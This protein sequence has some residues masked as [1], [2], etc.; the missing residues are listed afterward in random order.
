VF[1]ALLR[2]LT[3]GRFRCGG[4]YNGG[5]SGGGGR[6]LSV[7]VLLTDRAQLGDEIKSID[8]LRMD[9]LLQSCQSTATQVPQRFLVLL[10]PCCPVAPV[11]LVFL[12]HVFCSSRW[13]AKKKRA[14]GLL[15]K[16]RIFSLDVQ[17]AQ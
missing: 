1:L 11:G 4:G 13:R 9:L 17:A 15:L 2:P 7:D 14:I 5:G 16:C 6:S 12:S 10:F 3:W 8:G